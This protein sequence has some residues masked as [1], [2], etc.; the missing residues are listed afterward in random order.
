ML[1]STV[2]QTTGSPLRAAPQG[3]LRL[4]DDQVGG[5]DTYELVT[6]E[7]HAT[8]TAL[9]EGAYTEDTGRGPLVAAAELCQLAAWV[10]ADAGRRPGP[11]A[12]TAATPRRWC[13]RDRCVAAW[14][15]GV[16]Q[17]GPPRIR[18]GRSGHGHSKGGP[19]GHSRGVVTSAP[20]RRPA[21][22]SARHASTRRMY[23]RSR[24][25]VAPEP[26]IYQAR[27][28]RYDD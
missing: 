5:L 17:G 8:L 3:Q 13:P 11:A 6:G 26:V 23:R 2:T 12:P 10:S 22:R 16:G 19:S 21:F 7:L 9:R 14:W 28:V 1:L 25:P 4:L 18:H 24:P 20:T 15:T 27:R